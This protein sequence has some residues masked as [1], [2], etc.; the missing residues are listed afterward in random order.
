MR[1]FSGIFFKTNGH[2]FTQTVKVSPEHNKLNIH[3]I[4]CLPLQ[5]QMPLENQYMAVFLWSQVDSANRVGV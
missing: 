1:T 5:K 2:T 4:T 3:Y